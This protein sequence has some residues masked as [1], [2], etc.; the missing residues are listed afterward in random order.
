M[1]HLRSPSLVDHSVDTFVKFAIKKNPKTGRSLLPRRIPKPHFRNRLYD[2]TTF[3]ATLEYKTRRTSKMF[4]F[5]SKHFFRDQVAVKASTMRFLVAFLFFGVL[6]F[7][8][9][10]TVEEAWTAYKVRQ[11]FFA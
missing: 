8:Y 3:I 2:L 7:A 4:A 1:N 5:S 11:F 6:S 10:L 9:A